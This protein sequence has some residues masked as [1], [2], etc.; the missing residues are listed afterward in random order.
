MMGRYI[1]YKKDIEI[2]IF[3]K[4]ATDPVELKKIENAGFMKMI[5]IEAKTQEA[6]IKEF[7]A[8][9]QDRLGPLREFTQD[10]AFASTITALLL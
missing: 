2:K 4:N 6:A 9:A 8:V 5:V 3:E 10:T 7:A 1:F